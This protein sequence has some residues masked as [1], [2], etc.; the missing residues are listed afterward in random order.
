MYAV[1]DTLGEPTHTHKSSDISRESTLNLLQE[2][3]IKSKLELLNI[4]TPCTTVRLKIC[5]P[6]HS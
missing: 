4:Q 5:M 2:I 3:E 1:Y 6:V